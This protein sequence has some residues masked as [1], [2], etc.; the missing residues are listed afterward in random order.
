[1]PVA[2]L[3]PTQLLPALDWLDS[4]PAEAQAMAAAASGVA[5]RTGFRAA[6]THAVQLT[7]ARIT[8]ALPTATT[9][10]TTATAATTAATV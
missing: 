10:T 7:L 1:M 3:E 9:A 2:S 4:H 5:N 8:A 6:V